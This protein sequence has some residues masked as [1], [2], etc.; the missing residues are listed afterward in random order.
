MKIEKTLILDFV[1]ALDT[2]KRQT[3]SWPIVA[4]A[5]GFPYVSEDAFAGGSLFVA[6]PRLSYGA[7]AV[8]SEEH[9][10]RLGYEIPGNPPVDWE[11]EAKKIIEEKRAE[12]ERLDA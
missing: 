11:A 2:Q 10:L 12:V 4:D 7:E 8:F 6:A 5:L 1:F 3:R 9:V